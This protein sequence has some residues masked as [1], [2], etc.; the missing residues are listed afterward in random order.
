MS[1][2][3]DAESRCFVD[4][5]IPNAVSVT[6]LSRGN[7]VINALYDNKDY[8]SDPMNAGISIETNKPTIWALDHELNTTKHGDRVLIGST[9]YYVIGGPH[10]DGD[11]FGLVILSADAPR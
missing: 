4:L 9:T 7:A 3:T 8:L 11:G 2:L 1:Q 6:L 10:L 5:S